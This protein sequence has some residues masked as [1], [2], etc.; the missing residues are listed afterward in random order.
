M[1]VQAFIR[2]VGQTRVHGPGLVGAVEHF[3]K[4]LV[5]HNRQPLAAVLRVATQGRP[6]ARHK[7]GKCLFESVRSFHRVGV[8]V[9]MAA[10]LITRGIEWKQHFGRKFTAFFQHR[11]NGV[12]IGFGMGGQCFQCLGHLE[13]F[14]QHKLH[15]AQRRGIGGHGVLVDEVLGDGNVFYWNDECWVSKPMGWLQV[16]RFDSHG[17]HAFVKACRTCWLVQL[18]ACLGGRHQGHGS[19]FC[20]RHSGARCAQSCAGPSSVRFC[21]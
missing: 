10:L 8:S 3:I 21:F 2:A 14:V 9:P 16:V 13:Q 18:Q 11:R 4:T 1:G 17:G 19:R 7:L 6:T 12:G 20:P 5:D 15:V